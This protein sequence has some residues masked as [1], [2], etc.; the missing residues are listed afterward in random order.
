MKSTMNATPNHTPDAS[1]DI[2]ISVADFDGQL[3]WAIDI[4]GVLWAA[5]DCESLEDGERQA[6]ACLADAGILE[7]AED[8]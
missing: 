8:R 4:D 1:P 2:R 3:E 7:R 5:G 6:R